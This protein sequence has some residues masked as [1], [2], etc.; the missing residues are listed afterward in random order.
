MEYS[1]TAR[2]LPPIDRCASSEISRSKSVGEKE[3]T[4]RLLQLSLTFR[5]ELVASVLGHD[6]YLLVGPVDRRFR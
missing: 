3:A 5:P 1:K 6:R 4:T 2:L